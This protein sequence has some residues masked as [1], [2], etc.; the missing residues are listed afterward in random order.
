MSALSRNAGPLAVTAAA[1]ALLAIAFGLRAVTGLFVSPI[2]TATG[3]GFAAISFTLAIS[4]LVSGVAQPFLGALSDRHGPARVVF[5]GGCLLALACVLVPFA[6]SG[7]GLAV[8]FALMAAGCTAVGSTPALLGAVCRRVP[9]SRRGLA[10]GILGAGGSIG[11]LLLA[12]AT[13]AAIAGAGWV[14]AMFG[15]GL[16]SLAALPLSRAFVR[17]AGGIAP[18]TIEP[19][20]TEHDALTALRRALRAP[21]YWCVA[22]GFFVCGFHVSFLLAHMPGVIGTCAVPAGITGAWLAVLGLG[23]VAGSLLAGMA[24][25]RY[26]MARMLTTLYMLRALG[27]AA[28]LLAPKTSATLLGFA[29]WMGLTYMATVPPTSGLIGH[30]FGVRHLGVLF[31]VVMLVHQ[32]GSF[33]G[34]WLGGLALEATGGYDWIWTADVAL[35]LLAAAVHLPIRETSRRPEPAAA[36]ALEGQ[37]A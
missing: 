10:T 20:P 11:Q 23:N 17:P 9:E 22:A 27:V 32:I 4:Q 31:G 18:T 13:Q 2:N 12:P 16:L 33:L 7:I 3:I 8:A 29:V 15:L 37:P 1:T 19:H 24:V 5:A 30:L 26:P 28:F 14:G 6:Q 36:A 21:S 34:V 35:A 25:Q